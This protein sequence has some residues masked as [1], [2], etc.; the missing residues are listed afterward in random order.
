MVR[1]YVEDWYAPAAR[2]AAAVVG[3][4]FSGAKEVAAYRAKLNASWTKVQ[5]TGVDASGLPDT[6]V[7]G[8]PMTVRAVVDLAGLAP[9]DV[10]VEAVVGRVHETDE[11]EDTVR[12]AMKHV[13]PDGSGERF[14][15][16]VPLPHAGLTGYTVRVLPTHPLLASPAELGKVVLA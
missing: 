8:A 3:S 4:S 12:V 7:V 14:E 11:L 10:I 13:G 2:A 16:V 1:E 5:V 6:P 9:D 15:A